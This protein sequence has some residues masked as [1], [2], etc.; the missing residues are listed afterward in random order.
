M[1][2]EIIA[3]DTGSRAR[4]GVLHTPHGVVETP[5]FMPVGTAGTVKAIAQD[6]LEQLGAEIILA[7]T[8]HLY[9][10]PGHEVVRELGGLHHFMSWPHAILTDS[11]GYQVMSMKE[12]S[13]VTE[14]GVAFRSHLDGSAHFLTPELAVD[15]QHALGSD[16]MMILDECVEYPASH[17]TLHRAMK[18]TGRWADRAK[19]HWVKVREEKSEI[20]NQKLEI[21]N[22]K[23]K[24]PETE[25]KVQTSQ[26]KVPETESKLQ[27]P[28]SKIQNP[29][30]VLS[31]FALRLRTALSAAKRLRVNFANASKISRTPN[32]EPRTPSLFGIVQGGTDKDLRRESAEEMMEIGFDGYAIGGLSVGEPKSETCDVAEYTADLLPGDRPRYLMGVGTPEELVEC[33]ARGIDMFDCVMPTRNARNGTAFTSQGKLVVKN[34]AYAKDQAPLDPACECPVCR[35]YTRAYIRHLFLAHEMLGAMLTTSHNLYFY[36]DTMRRIRQAIVSGG[37][38]EYRSKARAGHQEIPPNQ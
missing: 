14:D 33:V 12:L 35:R 21:Q 24:M 34:A 38:Q 3:R 2:F 26:S 17:E 18:L 8:Y 16:I 36:L 9:L 37:F 19:K 29:R 25:P 13:R 1:R 6:Q 28:Q 7:N 23:F 31:P 22:S 15:I 10:R 20:R 5:V 11:G 27:S 30:L 4:A 32:P